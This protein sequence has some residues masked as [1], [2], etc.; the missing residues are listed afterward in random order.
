MWPGSNMKYWSLAPYQHNKV[1][2]PCVSFQLNKSSLLPA[3]KQFCL[4]I[5]IPHQGLYLPVCIHL[6]PHTRA[7]ATQVVEHDH[8]FS[9]LHQLTISFL[10]PKFCTLDSSECV[11]SRDYWLISPFGSSLR[12]VNLN[13]KIHTAECTHQTKLN[14]FSTQNEL[15][16]C[17]T[18]GQKII[19]WTVI[20]VVSVS[21]NNNTRR[22][23]VNIKPHT[24]PSRGFLRIG[25]LLAVLYTLC[26]Y[27]RTHSLRETVHLII[28]CPICANLLT[29]TLSTLSSIA[30][31]SG[32]PHVLLNSLQNLWAQV[33]E[34]IPRIIF[35]SSLLNTFFWTMPHA[36]LQMWLSWSSAP[37]HIIMK[38]SYMNLFMTLWLH[39]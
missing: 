25:R 31:F 37:I 4:Y 5:L 10:V 9:K 17:I 33:L 21:K 12:K 2:K 13:S 29:H 3:Y 36:T 16:K 34:L 38:Y 18:I 32:M 39:S 19:K 11:S 14:H 1:I 30:Q 6:L 22:N 20:T 8:N 27:L 24:R 28:C 15:C 23:S 7:D 35:T 26:C